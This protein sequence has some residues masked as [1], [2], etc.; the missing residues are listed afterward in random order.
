M[1]LSSLRHVLAIRRHGSLSKAAAAA[2]ISQPS[3]S[4]A[5]SRLEDELKLKLF[6]RGAHG[7][8]L[9]PIG[10]LVCERAE[11]ILAE[12]Q[13]IEREIA[14][15]AG[16]DGGEVRLGAGASLRASVAPR[17]LADIARRHPTLRLHLEIGVSEPLLARLAAGDLDIVLCAERRDL[18][19]AF[20]VLSPVIDSPVVVVASPRHPLAAEGPVTIDRV[21]DF[22]AISVSSRFQ[23]S[24]FLFETPIERRLEFHTASDHAP[25][26]PMLDDAHTV[27]FATRLAVGEALRAGQVV[28]L[29]M[30]D[31]ART[32][33]FSAIVLRQAAEAPILTRIAAYARAAA[34]AYLAQD[35]A[36]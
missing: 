13:G 23:R 10:E 14:L 25:C 15:I 31:Y 22:P 2:G 36:A 11:R 16:G 8:E 6:E 1:N 20:Q 28:A 24:D 18:G 32:V 17:L 21:A 26:L 7:A 33:R 12:V 9:T 29:R 19:P 30:A 4:Q 35:G 3:L 5:I 27:M 34:D